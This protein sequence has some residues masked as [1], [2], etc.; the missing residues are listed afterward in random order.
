MLI[1]PLPLPMTTHSAFINYSALLGCSIGYRQRFFGSTACTSR[2]SWN[3]P[4]M[5]LFCVFSF[6]SKNNVWGKYCVVD[7]DMFKD[8][9]S[10]GVC[11]VCRGLKIRRGVFCQV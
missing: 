5:K 1:F 7:P 6:W 8:M 10:R 9:F 4:G 3:N 2:V 11:C